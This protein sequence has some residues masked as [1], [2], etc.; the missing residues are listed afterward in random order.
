[1][2][3]ARAISSK[4]KSFKPPTRAFSS[5]LKSFG[6]LQSEGAPKQVVLTRSRLNTS[7]KKTCTTFTAVQVL[8]FGVFRRD[9]KGIIEQ[10]PLSL[11]SSVL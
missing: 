11:Q 3:P 9:I 4:L 5:N 1:M 2:P 10:K 6:A 8:Y 7:H